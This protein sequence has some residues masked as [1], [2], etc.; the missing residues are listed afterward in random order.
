MAHNALVEVPAEIGALL[1]LETLD[2]SKNQ[3]KS[4]PREFCLLRSLLWLDISYN[5]M[6]ELPRNFG[7]LTKLSV[8]NASNNRF[9]ML[10]E[11]F[12]E[13]QNLVMMQI[14]HNRLSDIPSK[15]CTQFTQLKSLEIDNNNIKYLPKEISQMTSLEVL[16]L[17][18]NLLRSVPLEL[19][20]RKNLKGFRIEIF[21][22]GNQFRDFPTKYMNMSDVN[23]LF[24][25]WLYEEYLVYTPS[26]EEWEVKKDSYLGCSLGLDN[27]LEGVQWRCD[28]MGV[29]SMQKSREDR[30]RRLFHYCKS[31]GFPPSFVKLSYDEVLERKQITSMMQRKKHENIAKVQKESQLQKEKEDHLYFSDFEARQCAAINRNNRFKQDQ[32]LAKQIEAEI[33]LKVVNQNLREARKNEKKKDN[34]C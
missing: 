21:L 29:D 32:Y 18:H 31:Y 7:S 15:W 22:E 8:L 12:E 5:K 34:D 25:E 11:S 10:P 16:S 27:F 19:G 1:L 2:L 33:L 6:T 3:L 20:S 13:L 24:F 14:S 23:D 9:R 28:R 4:L 26:V 30:I 17:K